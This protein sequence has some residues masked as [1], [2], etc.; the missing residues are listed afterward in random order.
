VYRVL[1][2]ELRSKRFKTRGPSHGKFGDAVSR[3]RQEAA[4]RKA[5]LKAD[6]ERREAK[7]QDALNAS[8]HWFGDVLRPMVDNANAELE[9]ANA[10]L[11]LTWEPIPGATRPSVKLGVVEGAR[12]TRFSF[13]FI[14]DRGDIHFHRGDGI[15][16]EVGK[17]ATVG[18]VQISD[19]LAEILRQVASM[20]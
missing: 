12:P 17:I 4:A 13:I 8:Q 20:L 7:Q 9:S 2:W 14:V 18:S 16:V 11:A 19:V 5:K 15:P 6:E 10:G 1:T 3:G